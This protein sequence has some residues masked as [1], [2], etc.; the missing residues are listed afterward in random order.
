MCY[1]KTKIYNAL[2]SIK[3][4]HIS[5]G[6]DGYTSKFSK[7]V[8]QTVGEQFCN[9][10]HEFF[11]SGHLLKQ[12]NHTILSMIPKPDRSV[13]DYR[14]IACCN[15]T[16]KVISR[17]LATRLGSTLGT[18]VDQAQSKFVEGRSMVENI[19]LAQELLRK[20]HRI[21]KVSARCILKIDLRKAFDS[22]DCDFLK[23]VL[24]GLN[25]LDKFISW[26]MEYVTSTSYSISL[27]GSLHDIFEGKR[28]L[29]KG[30]PLSPFLFVICIEYLSRSFNLDFKFHLRCEE[31]R[32]IH[33]AFADDLML[34]ARGDPTSVRILMEC[35][36]N[37]SNKFGLNINALKSD[38][39]TATIVG[40]DLE[41]I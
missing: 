24:E 26:V 22:V 41:E 29:R 23:S 2:N 8:W 32:I 1:K 38:L 15:V 27:N 3:K 16:Y 35:L 33:L 40:E 28:G 37:F 21:K 25:Y 6:P 5:P 19:H 36:S 11:D 7:K 12:I 39:Y 17:I 13:G 14:H 20:Y 31:N 9:V 18:I 10:V 30:D 34:M 4:R